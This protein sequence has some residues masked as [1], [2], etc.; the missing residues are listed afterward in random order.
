MLL[1]K[2]NKFKYSSKYK[3]SVKPIVFGFLALAIRRATLY[4]AR[5]V[6]VFMCE[7]LQINF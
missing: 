1:G 3:T 5:R 2:Q 4:E 6:E 7:T